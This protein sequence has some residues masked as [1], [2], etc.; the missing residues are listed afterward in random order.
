MKSDTIRKSLLLALAMLL[1]AGQAHAQVS[2]RFEPVSP[3]VGMAET[4]RVSV[5]LEEA[6]DIRTIDLTM[7]YDATLLNS[8]DV[9]KGALFDGLEVFDGYQPDYA[10][11]QWKGFTVVMSAG[12]W[13][14]GPGELI[15]WEVEGI[16]PGTADISLVSLTLAD[17]N[18]DLIEATF[19]DTSI[20]VLAPIGTPSLD[21]E[22][23]F[24]PGTENSVSW[25]DVGAD[26]YQ[27]Q[28]AT[29]A[30]F[31]SIVSDTGWITG[32]SH[33]FTGLTHGQIYYYRV[34]ARVA[35]PAYETGWDTAVVFSTQDDLPPV[36]AADPLGDYQTS[37]TFDIPWTGSDPVSGLASVALYVDSGSGFEL[38][39]T[40]TSPDLG[41]PFSFTAPD[42]G[43]YSFYTLAYDDVGNAEV[44]P[45]AADATTTVDVTAPTGDLL[46]NGGATLTNNAAVT[47][48]NTVTGATQMRYMNAGGAWST[49]ESYADTRSWT[50]TGPEGLNTVTA[51]F[52]DAAGNVHTPT[53]SITYDITPPEASFVING[54]DGLTNS[55]TVTL[56]STSVDAATMQFS[57]DG[58]TYSTETAYAVDFSW[59]LAGNEDL[60][61]VYARYYDAAGNMT[62]AEQTITLDTIPPAASFV[63]NGG[64]T[65]TNNATVELTSTSADAAQMQFSNDGVTYLPLVDFETTYPW[66]LAGVEGVNTVYAQ[67][68]DAAGNMTPAQQTITLDTVA[69]SASFVINGGDDYTGSTTV[70]LTSTSADASTMQ[71]S[72]DGSTYLPAVPYAETYTWE[73]SGTEGLNTVYGRYFDAAGN[74]VDVTDTITYDITPPAVSLEINGGATLTNNATVE[75]TST[76]TDAVT[77][78]FSN[79]GTNYSALTPYEEIFTWPLGGAEGLNTVYARYYDAAGNETALNASITLDTLPPTATFVING[80]ATLT[81]NATVELTSTSVDAAQMQFSNDGTTWSSLADFASTYAWDLAGIEGGNTVYAQYFDAAGN[82]TPL[83]QTI[84]LDTVDPTASFVIDADAPYTGST[85]V[86]LTSTSADAATMQFSNDGSTYSAPVPYEETYTWDLSG[87]EG[88]NTV[89]GRYFDAAGNSVEDTDTITYDITPP[90][91]SFVINGGATLTNN[92]T[93]ELTSTATDA[94][95]M[96][97]SND[98]ST[99]AAPVPFAETLSWDLAGTEGVNS[100]YAR[101]FDAAGNMTP[102]QQTITLDTIAPVASFLI[103]GGDLLT[104][105]ATVELTSTSADAAQMQFSN[106][107]TTWSAL[108]DFE[109]SYA[110]DLAGSEGENTV[111][112]QY[113][114]AAGNM[115]AAQ[116][117][118]NLDTV[119]PVASFVINDGDLITNST[120]ASLYLTVTG[121]TQM[122]FSNDGSTFSEWTTLD[123]PVDWTLAGP[124]G[125]VTVYGEFR[126]A[127][128]NVTPATDTIMLD[129]TAPTGTFV[130]NNDDPVTAVP[131]VTLTLDVTG[132]ATMEFSNNGTL[133]SDPEAYAATASW[134]LEGGDGPK[135]VHARFTDQAGNQLVVT[136]DIFLDGTAPVGTF[137]INNDETYTTAPAVTLNMSVTGASQMRFSADGSVWTDW[138][139]YAATSPWTLTGPDGTFTVFGEFRDAAL[140]TI[141]DDDEIILD[142]T[143]PVATLV[144]NGD[145]ALTNNPDV[146]LTSTVTGATQMRFSNNGA[147]WSAWQPA[148]ETLNWTLAGDQGLN[149]V[150]GEYRDAAGNVTPAEDDITLD[151]LAPEGTFVING[152]AGVTNNAAVTLTMTVTGAD[153]MQF[154]NDGVTYEDPVPYASSYPW[155]LTA[156]DGPKTVH[157]RF[158]D[159]A[160]NLWQLSQD[161][162]LDTTAPEVPVLL[163]EP[164][165]TAGLANTLAWG[166]IGAASYYLEAATEASFGSVAF[167]SGW[168]AATEHTFDALT[169]G[170]IYYYRLKAQDELGN[171]T[172][173]SGTAFSTQDNTAPVSA[174]EPLD[175]FQTDLVFTIPWTGS[176]AT[177][178]LASVE[179]FVNSGAGWSSAGT[180]TEVDPPVP[181]TYS[182]PAEGSYSFATV[183]T[184]GVGLVEEGALEAEATTAVDITAPA[185]EFVI[186]GDEEY[187]TDP[188]VTLT[189]DVTGAAQMQF[190]NDGSTW[191]DLAPTREPPAGPWRQAMDP[192]P[193]RGASWTRRAWN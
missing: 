67:F 109:P 11:G 99:F 17:G 86:T 4:T 3:T 158:T 75:L 179:L 133:W 141:A 37:S 7:A 50:L 117:T 60:N 87:T 35:T 39:L 119:Y 156:G 183:A 69:P 64:A 148:G 108:V 13:A 29:D 76:A 22:P 42:E 159:T 100:V 23:V 132:A 106:D 107:G 150:Y 129:T 21:A 140:N 43:T 66:D 53:A 177:S 186:N 172:D 124:D 78:Q 110:W 176:D 182:A 122:R 74:P 93:V 137:V 157:A 126:D 174:A 31:S 153:Q 54:G 139:D 160:G 173:W 56:T 47:L 40:N 41:A 80:G 128:L 57:N 190:S 155:N 193:C 185:G 118:I 2:L 161:I 145:V 105:N 58:V 20:E 134:T 34:Q 123:T 120:N 79:D 46:I 149:T 6:L 162:T 68:W 113:F 5:W 36:S 192:R 121:A 51:E 127:A 16:T 152:G 14:T 15:S 181:F 62:Q 27:I 143:F 59:D 103:N 30:G 175:P 19:P 147:D 44:A 90:T 112:A 9:S 187:T 32:T 111:Y 73:L 96:Q 116:Q 151:S 1:L 136:D 189:I 167:N 24:T 77:M 125:T 146:V 135:T 84:E 38:E 188:A 18:G 94:V 12:S 8:L 81:N 70:T 164:A 102:D 89:Y 104:N 144:I 165:F 138:E 52:R 163:A 25:N 83:Q 48:T 130:V 88:L 168:V 49:W 65:L 72:N 63:I 61:T 91:A 169:D 33:T 92:A 101:Y 95:T 28:A 98:G 55:A 26:E 154:S 85:T 82:M 171:E 114:D 10:A 142:T 45:L 71:F 184:D 115:T 166:D 170:Q 180:T 131:A 97:F 178:G 191:S